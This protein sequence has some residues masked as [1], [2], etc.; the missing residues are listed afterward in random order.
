[1]KKLLLAFLSFTAIPAAFAQPARVQFINNSPDSMHTAV[2][3]YINGVK[4]LDNMQ[5]QTATPFSD[6]PAGIPLILG[7][8]P[9]NSNTILDTFY[10]MTATLTAGGKYVAILNG[11]EIQTGYIPARP[12]RLDL[13]NAAREAATAP[14]NTDVLF[15]NGSTDLGT[16]DVRSGLNIIE[17]DI[18]FGNFAPAYRSFPSNTRVIARLTTPTGSITHQTYNLDMLP[19]TGEAVVMLTSG[20]LNPVINKNGAPFS[21][22]MVTAGGMVMNLGTS[23]TEEI[24]RLQ[25]IHNSADTKMQTVDIYMDDSLAFND[26]DFHMSSPF[27]D[28]HANVPVIWG[29]APANSTSVNDTFFSKEITLSG[30]MTH[31]AVINGIESATG[32]TPSKPLNINIFDQAREHGSSSNNVDMLIAHGS[33]DAPVIDL[34]NHTTGNLLVNDL[35][36]GEFSNYISFTPTVHLI[37]TTDAAGAQLIRHRAILTGAEGMAIT[38]VSAGFM[39]PAKNSNGIPF[40]Y[41]FTTPEGGQ[42][43]DVPEVVSVKDIATASSVVKI[44]PNPAADHLYISG[45]GNVQGI[46]VY[47]LAGREVLHSAGVQKIDISKLN[48]GVYMLSVQQDGHVSSHRFSKQ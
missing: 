20:F 18:P 6:M 10:T 31:V 37:N 13:F 48:T 45:K 19:Q 36:Y 42:L 24:C 39:D 47:D 2:D 22:L 35:G 15:A 12:L 30:G 32:Y 29:I 14:A 44:F 25:V 17:N 8:A 11:T 33:T 21:M 28:A 9:E 38:V 3:V 43:T 7:I 41:Y 23:G 16:I 27:L 34:R 4:Q 26:M 40:G 5:F 1:M 46:T